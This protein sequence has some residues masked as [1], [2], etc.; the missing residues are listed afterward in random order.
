MEDVRVMVICGLPA[1]EAEVSICVL[2]MVVTWVD[3]SVEVCAVVMTVVW[4]CI[5][6][7]VVCT[8]V[9]AV[10]V[11]RLL[12]VDEVLER[13]G[14]GGGGGAPGG[15]GGGATVDGGFSGGTIVSAGSPALRT[16]EFDG[17]AAVGKGSAA[18]GGAEGAS[19]AFPLPPTSLPLPLPSSTIVIPPACPERNISRSLTSFAT[20][21][22]A[23]ALP[24][25]QRRLYSLPH[26]PL[27]CLCYLIPSSI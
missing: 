8:E 10:D 26:D 11:V 12:D 24:A 6:V 16:I 21:I 13:A 4:V 19:G 27:G 18:T 20:S 3:T 7:C 25:Y 5:L 22:F 14:S 23:F 2:T 15:G 17:A 1:E 9:T